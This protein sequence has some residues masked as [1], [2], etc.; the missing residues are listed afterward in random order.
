M[1]RLLASFII[2]LVITVGAFAQ[3]IRESQKP[4]KIT[5]DELVAKHLA[6]I[7]TPEALAAARSRVL[8]GR[9]SVSS[10]KGYF[11]SV[12]GPVQIASDADRSL[13]VMMLNSKEYPYEKAAFDGKNSSIGLPNG[14]RTAFADF[15]K[16]KGSVLEDG[17][18]NGALSSKWPLRNLKSKKAKVEF[19]GS[20]K[21]GDRFYY[22]LRY[23]PKGDNLRVSLFFDPETFHHVITE[24]YYTIDIQIGIGSGNI[25]SAKTTDVQAQKDYYTLTERFDDFKKAGDLVLPFRYTINLDI[26]EHVGE[27]EN[28]ITRGPD[29]PWGNGS[30][31]FTINL[32]QAFFNEPLEASVFKVS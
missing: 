2:L 22:K 29:V 14:S 32:D 3:T 5:A 19:A 1:E 4:E 16:S 31:T 23:Y 9:A 30:L 17:L 10:V 28:D 18:F 21:F 20:V 27:N 26:R 6:S 7:G 13:F 8:I 24:Y 12:S 15:L 11:G 25:Q